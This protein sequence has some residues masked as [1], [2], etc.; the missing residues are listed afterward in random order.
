[1]PEEHAGQWSTTEEF[2][3]ELQ[4][5]IFDEDRI[6]RGQREAAELERLVGLEPSAR[7]LDMCCGPGRHSVP[8]AA[9]G[10]QVIGVDSTHRYL[11]TARE[12]AEEA[13]VEATFVH[14]DARRY[15]SEQPVDLVLNL[16]SSFGHFP[17]QQDN[18]AVLRQ[19][20]ASL[21]EGGALVL[22]LRSRETYNARQT[23]E[24]SWTERAGTLYLEERHVIDDWRRVRGRWIVVD[25]AGRR[26]FS[27]ESWLYSGEELSAMLRAA[28]F[29]DVSLY[30]DF[31][32][33]PYGQY[34]KH[35]VVIARR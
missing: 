35:L 33:A 4:D 5:V 1:M 32:G 34:S 29:A 27:Y 24:R 18:Q 3:A 23:A 17:D 26:D 22:H 8:L 19:A 25:S 11:E 13:G 16:W 31:G 7:I 30:G 12:L 10:H 9:R 6:R 2:W 21:R 28:G 15:R 20:R 14:A